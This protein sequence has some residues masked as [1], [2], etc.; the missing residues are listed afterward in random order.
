MKNALASKSC[1]PS[2]SKHRDVA[3]CSVVPRF[4]SSRS[5]WV[6]YA[7]GIGIVLVVYGHVARGVH[8]AGL[9]INESAFRLVDVVIYSFHMPLFFFLSGVFFLSS[10]Q[11]HGVRGTLA[12]K[13]RTV[14]WPYF[15]WSLLQGL[16][17]VQLARLTNGA[18]IPADVAALLWQ[19]RAQFWFLY[20]LFF[21]SVIALL[22]YR[23]L[24][25]RWQ[26]AVP[27]LACMV[28]L[29]ADSLP[30]GILV[31]FVTQ[32]VPYFACGVLFGRME[33]NAGRLRLGV[34][35]AAAVVVAVM[36]QSIYHAPLSFAPD[37]RWPS[38]ALALASIVAVVASCLWLAYWRLNWLAALGRAS[39]AIYLMHILAGSGTRI[40]MQK[41][42]GIESAVIHLMVGTVCGLLMPLIAQH[43]IQKLGVESWFG[44][45]GPASPQATTATPRL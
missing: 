29:Y 41:M 23:W 10:M 45:D 44:L 11:K 5:L 32:Y 2:P 19:P 12:V 4:M 7:K 6:D 17:E 38:L 36:A 26:P 9:P 20:T 33:E 15:V 37:V 35:A 24:S 8:S 22:V 13:L 1:F 14:A 40:V 25:V 39:L 31:S 28:Y 16:V 43:L 42:L 30:G 34:V 27:V 3:T 21:L 18:V